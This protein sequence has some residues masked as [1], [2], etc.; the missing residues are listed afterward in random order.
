MMVCFDGFDDAI[1]TRRAHA[2]RLLK[3]IYSNLKVEYESKLRVSLRPFVTGRSRVLFS[4]RTS[5]AVAGSEIGDM[6]VSGCEKRAR[7]VGLAGLAGLA[8]IA[9]AARGSLAAEILRSAPRRGR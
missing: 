3:L 5:L 8:F 4:S 2:L 7:E 1:Q 6:S 9:L